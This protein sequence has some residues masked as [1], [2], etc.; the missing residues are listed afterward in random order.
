MRLIGGNISDTPVKNIG[1]GSAFNV[2]GGA[3][4]ATD[5][6]FDSVVLLIQPHNGETSTEGLTDKGPDGRTPTVATGS[7]A[8]VDSWT[9]SPIYGAYLDPSFARV[10]YSDDA[11]I[12][13]A[14]GGVYTIEAIIHPQSTTDYAT[15]GLYGSGIDGDSAS[16][17][18][19]GAWAPNY[20]YFYN[21][22]G[23]T[24][25]SVGGGTGYTNTT[26]STGKRMNITIQINNT[27]MSGWVNGFLQVD[28]VG[29]LLASADW[30]AGWD[31]FNLFQDRVLSPSSFTG[32]LIALRATKVARYTTGVAHDPIMDGFPES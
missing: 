5:D 31:R 20:T 21:N 13:P 28:N 8:I 25:N 26:L 22:D 9:A 14:T 3:A 11:N 17:H 2:G 24:P 10:T 16:R 27:T 30:S 18:F 4:G 1:D 15:H 29:H 23:T 7:V 12:I 32:N 19:Q 6:H